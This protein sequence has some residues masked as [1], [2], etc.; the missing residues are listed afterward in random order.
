MIPEGYLENAQ[1]ALIPETNVKPEDKLE[2]TLVRELV[3]DAKEI[4]ELLSAFRAKALGEVMEFKALIAEKYNAHKGGAKGNM[5]LSS[6]DGREKVQVSVS[7]L[8]VLKSAQM[9]AAK[10]IL[11]DMMM[12]WSDGANDNLKIVFDQA[13]QVNK[14]GNID[15]QR[16]LSLKSLEVDDPDW[17]SFQKAIKDAIKVTSTK[18]YIRFYSEDPE[19]EKSVPIIL[20]LAGV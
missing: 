18:T 16:V 12:R 9:A 6:Y 14:Q 4:N 2:D 17:P 19:T 5:G 15:T 13:F 10:E 7:D 11:D 1:G 3:A 20:D 8:V